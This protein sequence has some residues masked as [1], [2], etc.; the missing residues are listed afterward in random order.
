MNKHIFA[1]I[2]SV[3]AFASI[4]PF[5]RFLE[6]NFSLPLITFGRAF[7]GFV[8]VLWIVPKLGT[9][10]MHVKNKRDF[11]ELAIVGL[12]LALTMNLY[13]SAFAIAPVA[14]VILLNYTHVF[15]APILAMI[16]L[17]EKLKF[18]SLILLFTGFLGLAIINPF[19]GHSAE[20]SMLALGA[21]ISYA[22]MAVYMRKSDR[23]HGLGNTAWFLGFA[24][25]FLLPGAFS[26]PSNIT[27]EG[28]LLLA[29]A[30]IISTGLGYLFFNYALEG[31]RVH[32]VSILDLVLGTIIGVALS[33]VAFHEALGWNVIVGGLIVVGSG[34]LFI[35]K[36][37]LVALHLK[38]P[39]IPKGIYGTVFI[40][41]KTRRTR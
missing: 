14:D 38:R 33:V 5:V 12:L 11:A 25:L 1:A 4:G 41:A 17:R 30:G 3:L 8:F 16:L 20:G 40:Q 13:N 9:E 23:H 21:G 18:D 36:Q 22:F 27:L 15:L 28:L 6:P 34:I 32:T 39:S 37:H 7:F 29:A 26:Q 2:M 10:T 24:S 19:D 31:L 35:R